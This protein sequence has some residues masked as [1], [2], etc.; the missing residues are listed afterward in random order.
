M[1]VL[2]ATLNETR[3]FLESLVFKRN[4]KDFLL[5]LLGFFTSPDLSGPVQQFS[6]SQKSP[7]DI[8]AL[9]D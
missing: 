7:A 8:L 2:K 6:K 3:T 1:Q 5:S 4:I 9:N